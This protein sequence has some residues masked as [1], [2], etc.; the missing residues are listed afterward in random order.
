MSEYSRYFDLTGFADSSESLLLHFHFHKEAKI[1]ERDHFLRFDLYPRT[2]PAHKQRHYGWWDLPLSS[3]GPGQ[4][5]FVIN[6]RSKE[7]FFADRKDIPEGLQSWTS[8]FFETGYYVLHV[9]IWKKSGSSAEMLAIKTL[10]GIFE[11]PNGISPLKQVH[12]PVTEQCNLRCPMCPRTK[13]GQLS[14]DH[15]PPAVQESLFEVIPQI[16]CVMLMALGEPLMYPQI[17]ELVARV[18]RIQPTDGE[19]G[20][21][22]NATLLDEVMAKSLLDAGLCF[23]YCS[24]D[25]ARASSY[26]SIRAGASFA[27]TTRNIVTVRRST[28]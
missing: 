11:T 12:I 20:I 7:F 10:D 25:G 4:S 1:F 2:A 17:A 15:M 22:S 3:I 26:E 5:S 6:A 21:T 24:V 27:E 28:Y 14:G 18:R 16:P 13:T 23:L 9:S 8:K 19:V